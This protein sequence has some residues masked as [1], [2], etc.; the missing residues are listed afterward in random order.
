ME[1]LNP[2]RFDF[3]SANFNIRLNEE[4]RGRRRD[5]RNAYINAVDI[6]LPLP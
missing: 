5:K 4:L 1:A 2:R 3:V 6:K